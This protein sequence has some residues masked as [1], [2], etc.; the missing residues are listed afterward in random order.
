MLFGAPPIPAVNVPNPVPPLEL[1]SAR[2]GLG[3]VLQQTPLAVIEDPPPKVTFPPLD[4]L[5]KVTEDAAVV[6]TVG[7]VGEINSY[8]P[9]S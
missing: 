8:A 7:D 2:V 1:R 3:E 4:A 6:V 9:I 5:V